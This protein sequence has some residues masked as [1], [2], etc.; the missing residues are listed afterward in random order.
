MNPTFR[1]AL[2]DLHSEFSSE[3]RLA[4]FAAE[5]MDDKDPIEAGR[6]LRAMIKAQGW[7]DAARSLRECLE[8]YPEESDNKSP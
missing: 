8:R 6:K 4:F 5:K 1:Q 7:A 2:W 3:G